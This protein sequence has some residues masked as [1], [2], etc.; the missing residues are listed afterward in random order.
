MKKIIIIKE[1]RNNGNYFKKY[2]SSFQFFYIINA[3]FFVVINLIDLNTINISIIYLIRHIHF[4]D[5][6]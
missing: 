3:T 5:S 6:F 4:F 1:Y 2:N